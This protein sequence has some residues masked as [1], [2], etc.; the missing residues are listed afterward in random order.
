MQACNLSRQYLDKTHPLFATALGN[1]GA[2]YH[3][4]ETRPLPGLHLARWSARQCA[5][6]RPGRSP[7]DR[8]DDR[9]VQSVDHWRGRTPLGS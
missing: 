5:D 9:Y 8:P 2:A 4:M 1:L 6:D 3:A 7:T